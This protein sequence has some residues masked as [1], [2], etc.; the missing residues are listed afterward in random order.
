MSLVHEQD[1]LEMSKLPVNEKLFTFQS[2]SIDRSI[3]AKQ[4]ENLQ[5]QNNKDWFHL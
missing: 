4:N 1:R 2:K 5:T 3:L